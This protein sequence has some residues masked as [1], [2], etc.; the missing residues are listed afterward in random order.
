M[1]KNNNLICPKLKLFCLGVVLIG[2]I[3]LSTSA[4]KTTQVAKVNNNINTIRKI[5]QNELI[6]NLP[7]DFG[8]KCYKDI[9]ELASY[10]IRAAEL[11]SETKTINYLFAKL[12]ENGFKE[13]QK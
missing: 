12:V 5:P 1:K 9:E 7:T 11:E 3:I 2:I 6:K 8:D 4:T 10:G 13:K